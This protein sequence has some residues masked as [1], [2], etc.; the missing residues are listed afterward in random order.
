MTLGKDRNEVKK[1]LHRLKV[2]CEVGRRLRELQFEGAAGDGDHGREL[3]AWVS[4][5]STSQQK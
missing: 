4:V 5:S 1:T 3:R 2:K